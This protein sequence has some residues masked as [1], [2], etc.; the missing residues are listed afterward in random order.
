[1]ID[2]ITNNESNNNNT[3]DKCVQVKI[4]R[5][6]KQVFGFD[7]FVHRQKEV[8]DCILSKKHALV[9]MPTGSG[10]SICYQLPALV[11][12]GIAIVISPLIS[13]IDEQIKS[14]NKL[15][16]GVASISSSTDGYALSRVINAI[17]QKKIKLL[18]LTPEKVIA[19][20]M[21]NLL[22]TVQISFFAIDEAHCVS[23]WG[24][25]FRYDYQRLSI[26]H[27]R[28]ANIPRIALTATLDEYAKIDIMHILNL[29]NAEIF[30][31]SIDRNNIFY[32]V[33]EKHNAKL[34][35]LNF[36]T[37]GINSSIIPQRSYLGGCGIIYCNTRKRTEELAQFL[38]SCGFNALCYHAG[39]DASTRLIN[40]TQFLNSKSIIMVATIAFGLGIDKPDI[41]FVYHFDM[42]SSID[43]FYQESGRAGR[44]GHFALSV[45]QYGLKDYLDLANSITINHESNLLV[46]YKSDL[47]KLLQMLQLCD[48]TGCRRKKLLAYFNELYLHDNCGSCDN[49][50]NMRQNID[51]TIDAQKILTTIMLINKVSQNISIKS[52]IDVLLG[53]HN[54]WTSLNEL[55][56]VATFGIFKHQ[57]NERIIRKILRFLHSNQL[58]DIDF[59]HGKIGL[60]QKSFEIIAGIKRIFITD[61][62]K[63]F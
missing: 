53:R 15:N 12:D 27:K 20:W 21:L 46:K 26:L 39:M 36:L 19:E 54:A 40:Q 33:Q 30:S 57:F 47:L 11:M 59:L 3:Y 24:H 56:S 1:M 18:Y 13:L 5:L 4:N 6:L 28:F 43:S 58:I 25:S 9:I 62:I 17:K 2:Q 48:S 41:R 55:S 7:Q 8:I 10:K 49:C 31:T 14:L 61:N 35:L 44:D 23:K 22:S 63:Y 29:E 34:Q 16:I 32:L 45:I 38:S 60:N 52:L 50:L 37:H 42:P 51:K